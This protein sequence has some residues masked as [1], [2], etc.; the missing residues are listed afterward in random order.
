MKK[1]IYIL[2]TELFQVLRQT[3]ILLI[4]F[5][6]VLLYESIL[7]P[8]KTICEES[9]FAVEISEPF[10]LLCTR[11]TNVVLI[12]LIYL[13]LLSNFPFCKTQYFQ[14]IRTKKRYWIYGEV[15]FI[16]VSSFLILLILFLGSIFFV[17]KYICLNENWSL[18][19]TQMRE[20]F[21]ELYSNNPLLFLDSSIIA[22]GNPHQVLFYSFSMMWLYLITIGIFMLFGAIIGKETMA[23]I[24]GTA[25]TVVGGS[26]I[27]FGGSFKW[28]F[29]LAHIEFGLHYNSFFSDINFPLWGSVLY[30]L[31][32][33][34]GLFV[35]CRQY[36]KTMQ[37][38]E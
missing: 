38:G 19:M 13:L 30:L 1:I 4:L 10:I 3:K 15:A 17:L 26:A 29:P 18:Y 20:Q 7:S 35:L 36:L 8:M 16:I 21:P 34:I 28:I 12:P 31:M 6:I 2:K 27:Y 9:K 23:M 33:V 24:A 11:S 22:H 37:I 14:I 32:L 25:V 5:F